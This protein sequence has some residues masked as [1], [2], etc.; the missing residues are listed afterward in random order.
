MITKV[1]LTTKNYTDG[2]WQELQGTSKTVYNPSNINEKV[3]DMYFSTPEQ[4]LYTVS[5]AQMGFNTWRKQTGIER[6][7]YLYKMADE[8]ERAKE[9]VA[10]LASREM[11]KP[12]SE[13]LGE[14]TRGVNLL[15]YYAAEGARA[16]GQS[17]PASDQ[18]VLQYTKRVPLGVVAVITPW[19]F[20]VAI[21]IWKI[22]PALIC[23]NSV[24]WKPA[25]NSA[26]TA[27]RLM[28]IFEK[29]N[30]PKGVLN[31][32]IAKGRMI[33]DTLLEK[34]DIDAVSFT[35]S[36]QTGT[37]IA[38]I[39]A[40]RNIKFQTEMGGKNAAVI[41][42]DADLEKTIPMILSGAFRS[43]GQK[44][45]ATSRIIVEK[46]IF[47]NF[48]NSLQKA[49]S[50]LV[51]KDALDADAYLG[52]VASKDQYENIS[53]YI[54]LARKEATVIAEGRLDTISEGYYIPPIVVSGVGAQHKLFKEEIFGPVTVIIQA[55]NF[56]EAIR[57]CNQSE[58][59]LSASIFT[60]NMEKALLFLEEAEVGMVRVNQETAGV[61]YQVPFGGM[62]WSSSHT[63][64]QG[65]AAL[66][67]YSQV[68]TC[69]IKYSF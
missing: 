45:T 9:E 29:A 44:C 66:D 4:I 47:P 60:N 53:Q 61:E 3:G 22:A 12:I 34:A 1:N 17:V 26:L 16:D 65:Q 62:K 59:G 25:E 10:T 46:E 57:L 13:M 35:G 51:V 56:D 6:A 36:T 20:P 42:N 33:G 40:K 41:L 50:T 5:S 48:I 27:T 52:P 55:E 38:S 49:M 64:E 8:L 58:Y 32:V 37:Q 63:R 7:N 2:E 11:G 15:R 69:A 14:V 30:L 68:K 19:N 67:F 31:L 21:P 18:H 23:G 28:E 39:C 43:A 24:V 54:E